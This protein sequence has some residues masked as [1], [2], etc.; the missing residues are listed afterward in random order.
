MVRVRGLVGG[1]G[2]LGRQLGAG[3]A[4]MTWGGIGQVDG[5]LGTAA[6]SSHCIPRGPA[7]NV[8]HAR[9]MLLRRETC[10]T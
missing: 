7:A 5:D 3:V 4:S 6:D 2:R 1:S 9:E 8:T 10:P